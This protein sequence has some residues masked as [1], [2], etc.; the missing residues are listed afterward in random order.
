MCERARRAEPNLKMEQE[1]PHEEDE[2]EKP[3]GWVS[4]E[5]D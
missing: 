4:R 1:R 3:N 5:R 2:R